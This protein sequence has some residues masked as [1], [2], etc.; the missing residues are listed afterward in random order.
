LCGSCLNVGFCKAH[1]ASP[2]FRAIPDLSWEWSGWH[3]AW[4]WSE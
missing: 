2:I 1:G 4:A 3:N